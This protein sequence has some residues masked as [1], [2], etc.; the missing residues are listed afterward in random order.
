MAITYVALGA[1]IG[2]PETQLQRALELLGLLPASQL[3]SCSS[4]YTSA[5]FGYADQP[6]FVNAVACLETTMEPHTLMESLFAIETLLGR[7]RTFK[8]A[9]RTLDLDLLY[10][11]GQTIDDE[12]LTIPH[13][14]MHERAFVMVPLAEIAPD[15]QLPQGRVADLARKVSDPTLRRF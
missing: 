15:L 2:R 7:T 13:P 10:Y 3:V 14:R 1:N 5:P 6:D 12:L 9:P 4:L 11:D 8:N